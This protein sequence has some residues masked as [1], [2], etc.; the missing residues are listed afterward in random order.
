MFLI[1][2]QPIRKSIT[3]FLMTL[4]FICLSA[5]AF[6]NEFTLK[7]G[8][9]VVVLNKADNLWGSGK[10][11][12]G[13]IY[14]KPKETTRILPLPIIE[15]GY[16]DNASA[17]EYHAGTSNEEPGA[18]LLGI[19]KDFD[20]KS[21]VE[22]YGFYSFVEK[23]WR[24]PYVLNR[25]STYIKEY[26]GK[27]AFDY[28][29]LNIAYRAAF[30]DVR[31]DSIGDLYQDL[32]RDGITH[33]LG[34]SYQQMLSEKDGLTPGF[35]YETAFLRGAGN[36]YSSYELFLGFD[37][38]TKGFVLNTKISAKTAHFNKSN[39]VFQ[40]TREENTYS[41]SAIAVFPDPF[42]F[43]KYFA[44]VGGIAS[45]TDSNLV[46]FAEHGITGFIAAGYKF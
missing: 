39:P 26:G 25:E 8:G 32:K 11:S 40:K 10:K 33:T 27:I 2:Q 28:M 29:G 17:T 37:R 5:P 1:N 23:G 18:F 35:S 46:F 38:H 34:I 43:K 6:A 36:S 42:G 13:S 21:S 14:E 16:I 9:G 4:L 7:A 24:N 30:T 12:I 20:N 44:T 3:V 15:A 31:K 41:A 45:R 19:D 22:V